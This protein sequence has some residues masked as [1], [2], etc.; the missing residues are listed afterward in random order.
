MP[1][2]LIFSGSGESVALARG[3]LSAGIEVIGHVPPHDGQVPRRFPDL[4]RY[5]G[6]MLGSDGVFA[7]SR[8]EAALAATPRFDG[9]RGIS[10]HR[11]CAKG[12]LPFLHVKR[13]PWAPGPDDDWTP[14]TSGREALE[15]I[16]PG[17]TVF[18]ATGGSVMGDFAGHDGP[19]YCRRR[20]APR[21]CAFP[22]AQGGWSWAR[23]P[24]EAR[25][26]IAW[27]RALRIDVLV[28]RNIGG[29]GAWPKVEAAR[30]L[31]LPVV[32]IETRD[33]PEP[34]VRNVADALAWVMTL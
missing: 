20:G 14:V 29:P 12:G 15:T 9:G 23:P 17:A 3:L 33:P 34:L 19:I 30:A 7:R 6:P 25:H 13:A 10:A 8:A 28:T 5:S 22:A 16:V 18:L 24:F 11:A 32:M 1:R 27:F 31:G 2:T 21:A 4:P 26:E